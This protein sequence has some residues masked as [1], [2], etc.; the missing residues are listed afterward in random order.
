MT[1]DWTSTFPPVTPLL[2]NRLRYTL[3]LRTSAFL[4]AVGV[5]QVLPEDNSFNW[6]AVLIRL[7]PW[8][9][10]QRRD[11]VMSVLRALA[12]NPTLAIDAPKWQPK[13]RLVDVASHSMTC[14]LSNCHRIRSF[15]AG[16]VPQ[17]TVLSCTASYR[18]ALFLS[19]PYC[20]V[21]H[22]AV[23]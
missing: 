5:V 1:C 16:S 6:G 7:L 10:I 9:Q 4:R 15:S 8:D 17:F 18:T 2:A 22:R 23:V 11:L 13:V 12:N 20:T 14:F 21:L 3:K 19:V